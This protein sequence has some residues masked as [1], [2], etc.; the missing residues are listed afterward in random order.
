MN[1]LASTLPGMVYLCH[2]HTLI[3]KPF[4][5]IKSCGTRATV[6]TVTIKFAVIP[7]MMY[8]LRR[9]ALSVSYTSGGSISNWKLFHTFK[10]VSGNFSNH[11]NKKLTADRV[12]F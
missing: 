8:V 2:F 11:S 4:V 7:A 12:N 6:H 1:T 5:H 9:M 3:L 10:G